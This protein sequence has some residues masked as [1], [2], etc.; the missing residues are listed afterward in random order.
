ME[1]KGK[2]RI[3]SLEDLI[4]WNNNPTNENVYVIEWVYD[5]ILENIKLEASSKVRLELIRFTMIYENLS[6][7]SSI[8]LVDKNLFYWDG[9]ASY[10]IGKENIIRLLGGW[11]CHICKKYRQD[12]FISVYSRKNLLFKEN[13]RYCNDNNECI[14]GSKTYKHIKIK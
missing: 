13:I 12:Y 10:Y 9:R 3:E 1:R 5:Y 11:K 4:K 6:K 7:T 14:K 8:D 2:L